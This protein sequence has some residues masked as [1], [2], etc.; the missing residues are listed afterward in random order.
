MLWGAFNHLPC[1]KP[2]DPMK[3]VAESAYRRIEASGLNSSPVL[4]ALH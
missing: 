2:T 3:A 1:E 4:V